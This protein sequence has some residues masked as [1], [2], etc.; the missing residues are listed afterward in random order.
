[1]VVSCWATNFANWA[2]W[3]KLGLLV[4]FHVAPLSVKTTKWPII[5]SNSSDIFK[6]EKGQGILLRRMK[7]QIRFSKISTWL[8]E[9]ICKG[10]VVV[11]TCF[12][13]QFSKLI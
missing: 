2:V 11:M 3:L 9:T 10:R 1:M 5:V 8:K 4:A 12:A 13:G 6:C 7:E